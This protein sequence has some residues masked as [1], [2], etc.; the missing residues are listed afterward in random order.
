MSFRNDQDAQRH[1]VEALERELASV[2]EELAS[3]VD[4]RDR[5]LAELEQLRNDDGSPG[6]SPLRFGVGDRVYVE[7]RG[8]WW[9]ARVVSLVGGGAWRIHYEGWSDRWD[10]TVG[11]TRIV[12][13]RGRP[14]GPRGGTAPSRFMM[15]IFGVSTVI[16]IGIAAMVFCG[17]AARPPTV[18][19][20][21]YTGLPG[22]PVTA[23]TEL[24]AGTPVWVEW[25]MT[26]YPAVVLEPGAGGTARIRY[27]NYSEAYDETVTPER[28]RMR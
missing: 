24:V 10:E 27:E 25:N 26:W 18:T 7:W 1:R 5:A 17:G 3:A 9:D 13:H 2:R 11:P 4:G 19:P 28:I 21:P 14:P 16:G 20:P 22:T 23:S 6:S 15:A 8:T 12:P